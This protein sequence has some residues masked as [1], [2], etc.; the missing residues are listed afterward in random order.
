MQI[1]TKKKPTFVCWCMKKENTHSNTKSNKIEQ[2]HTKKT[3]TPTNWMSTKCLAMCSLT[4]CTHE[5]LNKV[6]RFV[7]F[8]AFCSFNFITFFL[9]HIF[10]YPFK[11]SIILSI[12]IQA[13]LCFRMD[14]KVH[15]WYSEQNPLIQDINQ[16]LI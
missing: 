15:M 16:C 4:L 10:R 2:Q 7:V 1:E 14:S 5:Y 12:P 8:V 11:L 6:N 9:S 13:T 3:H